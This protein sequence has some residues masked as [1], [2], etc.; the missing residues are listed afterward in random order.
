[1]EMMGM[2]FDKYGFVFTVFGILL[3][4]VFFICAI[5]GVGKKTD[6]EDTDTVT[7]TPKTAVKPVAPVAK[8]IPVRSQPTR[9]ARPTANS[10]KRV[11]PA[12]VRKP[13]PSATTVEVEDEIFEFEAISW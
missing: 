11:S 9:P 12:G 13:A 7:S 1:M 10:V 6:K 8:T 5:K 4:V 3:L 2:F